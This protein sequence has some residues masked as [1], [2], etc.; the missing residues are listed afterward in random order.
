MTNPRTHNSP[1][2]FDHEHLKALRQDAGMS[3]IELGVRLYQLGIA[4]APTSRQQVWEWESGACR[5]NSATLRGLAEIFGV[6]ME[7]FFKK[8]E[9]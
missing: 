5:P 3:M 9:E 6:T 2:A 7:S 4:K 8:A 1:F